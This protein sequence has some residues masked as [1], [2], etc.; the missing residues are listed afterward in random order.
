MILALDVG[1]TSVHCGIFQETSRSRT[2]SPAAAWRIP[3]VPKTSG[4]SYGKNIVRLLKSSPYGRGA[5]SAVAVASVVP[6]LDPAFRELARRSF[7]RE[8]FFVNGAAELPLH[9]LA[10]RPEEVGADRLANAAASWERFG[11]PC[12]V[13]DFGT[14]TTFDCVT[15]QG[16]YIGGLI[17]PGPELA[18]ESLSLRTA[19]LPRVPIARPSRLIGRNTVEC[20]RSGLYYGLAAQVDGILDRLVR[21][22]GRSTRIVACGGLAGLAAGASRRITKAS[23][24]PN[25]T[26]QGIHL[27]W[28]LNAPPARRGPV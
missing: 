20:I 10:D 6:S 26:L 23:I 16:E 5:V 4:A 24:E 17:L 12:V 11:G 25:L 13:V 19:K 28:R 18:S 8:A 3:T 14:A 15:Q 21:E 1:N 27:I 22:L 7:R 2:P 9:N